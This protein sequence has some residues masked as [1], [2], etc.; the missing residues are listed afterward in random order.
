LISRESRQVLAC[1]VGR[2]GRHARDAVAGA[3]RALRVL[4]P[5]RRRICPGGP[6]VQYCIRNRRG[7]AASAWMRPGVHDDCEPGRPSGPGSC[8]EEIESGI[9]R[10]TAVLTGPLVRRCCWPPQAAQPQCGS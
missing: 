3:A 1:V 5:W 7:Q 2:E 4:A 6:A 9:A 8:A 10:L